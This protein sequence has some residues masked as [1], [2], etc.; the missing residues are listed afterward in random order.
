MSDSP[1]SE[2]YDIAEGETV[3]DLIASV[4]AYQA[5]GW[6]PLGGVAVGVSTFEDHNGYTCNSWT[7]VQAM[8][9]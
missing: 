3:R 9:K 8:V 5:N 7:Y 2:E 6:R 4:K 1:T